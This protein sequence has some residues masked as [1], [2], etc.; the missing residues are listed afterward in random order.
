MT[1]YHISGLG[2]IHEVIRELLSEVT[3]ILESIAGWTIG[4]ELTTV[5]G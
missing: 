1:R 2:T 4:S 5:E 3:L